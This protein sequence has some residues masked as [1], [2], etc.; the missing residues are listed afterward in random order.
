M[1][2]NTLKSLLQ[3]SGIVVLRAAISIAFIGC[4]ENEVASKGARCSRQEVLAC[5][6]LDFSESVANFQK[7]DT[8]CIGEMCRS[9]AVTGGLVVIYSIGETDE[10]PGLRCYL[11][12]IPSVDKDLTLSKQAEFKHKCDVIFVENEKQIHLFL[13]KVQ[14]GIFDPMHVPKRKIRNTDLNGFFRKVC[15]LMDEP[16]NQKMRKLV[17]CYSD[18][19]NSLNSKDTPADLSI[20]PKQPFTLC[21][22]GWRAKLP[23]SVFKIENF[24]S[25]EGFLKYLNSLCSSVN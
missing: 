3:L 22:S 23:P 8:T 5:V 12:P 1:R 6:G 21:L 19:I 4:N 18:G 16:S 24:E 10:Q 15:I 17:F 7:L 11:K 13:R 25:P 14:E 20:R 9:V 2:K